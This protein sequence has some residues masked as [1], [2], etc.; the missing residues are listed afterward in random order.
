M[1]LTT[2]GSTSN[3]WC[4]NVARTRADNFPWIICVLSTSTR[5]SCSTTTTTLKDELCT[6]PLVRL[7]PTRTVTSTFKKVTFNYYIQPILS[8]YLHLSLTKGDLLVSSRQIDNNWLYGHHLDDRSREG[9]FPITHV[10]RIQL[11]DDEPIESCIPLRSPSNSLIG[12]RTAKAIKRFDSDQIGTNNNQNIYLDLNI[13]DYL[14]ISGSAV[15][16]WYTGENHLGK[17]GLFPADC[18]EFV[19]NQGILQQSFVF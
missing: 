7:N 3:R 10:T 17:K 1:R 2:T 9:I 8:L 18:V 11:F 6:F 5:N 13:G 15:N 14:L 16:G 12:M 19:S 4:P